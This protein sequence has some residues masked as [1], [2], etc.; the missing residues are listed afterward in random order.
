MKIFITGATGYIGNLLAVK[1]AGSGHSVHALVRKPSTAENMDHSNIRL[2]KG[3][4]N[5]IHSIRRA[6]DDC[7]QVF[8]V[9]AFA[10]LWA[11][12]SDIFF[13]VNVD[14]T[15]NVLD[16]AMEKNISKFVY[17]SSTAVFGNSLNHPLSENDPRTIGF[18]CD[19]DLSKCMAE[20]LVMDYAAKG[21]HAVVVN[22]SR[23]YGPGRAT[24]SNPFTRFMM[25]A[26]R[27][28]LVPVPKCPDVI[29]N[30]AYVHDVIAGHLLAMEHG[31]RGER[32]ILGGEN[33][34]YRE[35]LQTMQSI[36]PAGRVIQ[37]PKALLTAIGNFQLLRFYVTN[38]H[39]S[40]TPST[41][42]RYYA[43]TA[44]SCDK[45]ITQLNYTITPFRQ[46]MTETIE[47]LKQYL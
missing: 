35:M 22:P 10:R 20:K 34:S 36:I 32:Y 12:P 8:H 5:D 37:I 13:R 43:H 4:L 42:N 14:G 45:A 16:V 2:F 17:T 21:L 24:Y 15:R 40:F 39:P 44:F 18:N 3:D 38:Q 31:K 47:H 11:H 46:G 27:G 30:Y 6:M 26:L 41:I 19:Y 1:L 9:A 25:K 28:R 33:I 23:V 29:A 7:E